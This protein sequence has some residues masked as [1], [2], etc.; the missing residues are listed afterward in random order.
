[1]IYIA[2]IVAGL[3]SLW[4]TH[5]AFWPQ[6][7]LPGNRVRYTKLR[8]HLRLHPGRGFATLV[9]LWLFWSKTAMLRHSRRARGDLSF[10]QRL[11]HPKE[12]S[13]FIGRGHW[14]HALRILAELHTLI[15]SPPR[16]G[17]TAWLARMILRYPGPL[18]CTSIK[19]DLFRFTSGIRA[20]TGRIHVFNPQN[21]GGIRSTFAINVVAGCQVKETAIRR[22]QTLVNAVDYSKMKD[23]DWFR[24]KASQVLE[25]L[26][27]AA[28]LFNG[29]LRMISGWVRVSTEEAQERLKADNSIEMAGAL[30]EL[31]KAPAE[32]TT[33]TIRMVLSQI[34]GFMS[35]P[36]VAAS[37]LPFQGPGFDPGR[38][39]RS[40]DTLYLITNSD[41]DQSPLAPLFALIL[42]E[43]K[44]A[45]T[46]IAQ[47]TGKGRLR[48]PLGYFLDEIKQC[49]PVPV[50]K[51]LA[52][53]GGL[54]LQIFTVVH[55]VAQ[56]RSRWGDNGAQIIV[57]TCGVKVLLPGIQD[58]RTL[59]DIEKICGKVSFTH[60]GQGRHT[61]EHP[62]VTEHPVIDAGTLRQLPDKFGLVIRANLAPVIAR[63]PRV[64]NTWDYRW[65]RMRGDDIAQVLSVAEQ[66][67]IDDQVTAQVLEQLED[68][69]ALPVV[70]GNGH[71]PS[72]YPWAER[73]CPSPRKAGT[74]Q[75]S[76][77]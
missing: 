23:G 11:R 16:M 69:P 45:A 3:L 58:A 12:H 76:P 39:V 51:W 29:D 41:Q 43:I 40:R 68:V 30:F 35:D 65:A 8:L 20:R 59:D 36:A 1:M 33:A 42:G 71:N 60:K 70:R 21:I 5:W 72:A 26:L 77:S 73:L 62:V 19:D 44:H 46:M 37:V 47:E 64:W 31:E 57:D 75:T 48:R 54:G 25:A 13:V 27:Y 53:V 67:A 38:F 10:W 28:A 18:A 15:L 24:D 66:H 4:F 74:P 17:K 2:G 63:L 56:L 50:D 6:R 32:K 14:R 22:A 9:E 34:L 52:S 49:A 7:S 61:P 55:D